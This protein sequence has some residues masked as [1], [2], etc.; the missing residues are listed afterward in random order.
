MAGPRISVIMPAHNAAATIE[1]ALESLISQTFRDLEVVVVDDGSSDATAATVERIAATSAVPVR[2]IGQPKAGRAAARN[3]GIGNARAE[4]L[5][6]VDA[7][8]AAEPAMFERLLACADT[9]GADLVVCE[10]LGVDSQTGALLYEYHEGDSSYYGGSVVER[11]GL[12]SQIAGSVCNKLVHRS[13]F[14][15]SGIEFPAGRDF[16]DLATV[17]RLMGEAHR[18]E[19]VAEPLYQYRHRQQSSIMS[20]TDSRYLQILDALAVTN[21]HFVRKGDFE[22]LRDDLETV[23]FTHLILGRYDDLF[24]FASRDLRHEFI[25][26]AFMHM[27]TYF[28]GWRRDGATRKASGRTA[29]F[30]VSTNRTLLRLYT[31]LTARGER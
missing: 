6:F 2:L 10:Y 4:F 19:K 18:I 21:D 27:D 24:R 1:S 26:R 28:P 14:D 9:T 22:S 31:D 7:D 25:V 11:P 20:A 8:D 17:Y 30:A 23:N 13:L 12:L 16:E 3:A 15:A 5:G 29:R